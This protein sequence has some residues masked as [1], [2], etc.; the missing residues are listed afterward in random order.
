[1][2]M[3]MYIHFTQAERMEDHSKSEFKMIEAQKKVSWS[4]LPYFNIIMFKIT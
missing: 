3:Y 2:Y 1:M 4:L